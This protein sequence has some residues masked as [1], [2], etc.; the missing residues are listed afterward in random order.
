[1]YSVLTSYG[2][3]LMPW[4]R[5]LT[6]S[7]E[8]IH[9][10]NKVTGEPPRFLQ[11]FILTIGSDWTQPILASVKVG[12]LESIGFKQLNNLRLLPIA[13]MSGPFNDYGYIM[14]HLDQ[15]CKLFPQLLK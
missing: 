8:L 4:I 7:M 1:M 13:V 2:L 5:S 10:L 6:K 12:V 14:I 15:P 11:I 9:H 3:M